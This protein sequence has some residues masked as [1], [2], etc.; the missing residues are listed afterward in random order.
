VPINAE[1]SNRLKLLLLGFIA[2][3]ASCEYRFD[4]A[5]PFPPDNA[6]FILTSDNMA[7]S[8]FAVLGGGEIRTGSADFH[9]DAVVRANY[10]FV[11]VLNR[12]G[13]DNI[14]ILHAQ[15][16]YRTVAE[17]SL[18]GVSSA[19]A[20]PQDIIFFGERALVSCYGS[21]SLIVF[22]TVSYKIERSIDLAKYGYKGSASPAFMYYDNENA[23]AFVALQRLDRAT[24]LPADYSTVLVLSPDTGLVSDEIRLRSDGIDYRN[25]YTRFREYTDDRLLIGCAGRF[26]ITGSGDDD[27]GIVIIRRGDSHSIEGAL[28]K[29][30]ALGADIVD[31]VYCAGFLYIITLDVDGASALVRVDPVTLA[32]KVLAQNSGGKGYLWRIETRDNLLYVCNRDVTDSGIMIYDTVAGS[33]AGGDYST[34]LPPADMAFVSSEDLRAAH[35]HG[36][37]K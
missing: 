15:D 27:G 14:Q 18:G 3:L 4:E 35:P 24:Y 10:P 21:D 9:T 12:L 34:G 29:E 20:N 25:P 33:F 28:V 32:S 13:R 19:R 26:K 11:Y 5:R 6:L 1:I 30:S 31:F 17:I 7:S 23:E 22:N 8:G 36:T 37:D 16:N 2:M